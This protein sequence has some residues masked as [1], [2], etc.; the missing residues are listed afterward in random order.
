LSGNSIVDI[1]PLMANSGISYGS[2]V[3]ISDN[4]LSDISLNEYIPQL[5]YRGVRLEVD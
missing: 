1:S 5:S 4:P 3:N 2:T